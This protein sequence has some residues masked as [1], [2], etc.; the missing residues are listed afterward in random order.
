MAQNSREL[1]TNLFKGKASERPPFC[2]W[3]CSFAAKLEQV[4]VKSMLSDPGIL[5]RA[6]SNAHKLFG[7]D[8]LLNH[9]DPSL[10]AEALGCEIKWQE[11]SWPPVVTGHPLEDMTEFYDLETE[12]IE[13]KGR[14][15]IVIEATKRLILTKKKE[16]PIAAMITG[17]LTLAKHLKGD[18]FS[19]QL[20]SEDEEAL[21]LVEDTGSICLKLCRAYCELGVDI[22]V[23]AEN[24]QDLVIPNVSS[25]LASPLKS[26]FNVSRFYN[27][28]SI[29]IGK[30]SDD[31]QAISICRLG[32][33]AVSLSGGFNIADAQEKARENNIYFSITVP[34]T[35]FLRTDAGNDDLIKLAIKAGD[36][37]LFLSS[38]WEVPRGTNVNSMH[39]IMKIVRG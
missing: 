39:E 24:M 29:L 36:S 34:D 18:A 9:F 33:D 28:N 22:I 2:P 1:V 5:S 15:P 8:T 4:Q 10:E 6:L 26:I 17:P 20:E 21:D 23:I 12:G 3:V 11:D 37:G 30:I 7:Y 19:R 31:K 35:A 27:V 14:I 32:A 13:K 16:V 38:E 25:V